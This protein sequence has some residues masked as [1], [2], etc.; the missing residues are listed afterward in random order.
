MF[1]LESPGV[2]WAPSQPAQVVK[3]GKPSIAFNTPW[4]DLQNYTTVHA[5]SRPALVAP[6]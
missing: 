4:M 2:Y 3:A 1:V 5:E 6:Q